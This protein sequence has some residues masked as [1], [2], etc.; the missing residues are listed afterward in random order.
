[1]NHLQATFGVEIECYLP[2]G[3]SAALAATAV[4]NRLQANGI[5]RDCK[6]ETLNK[7]VVDHWKIVPDGSLYDVERGVEFV[8]PKLL[9]E[10]GLREVEIVANALTDFGCSVSRNCGLHV[11]VGT[12]IVDVKFFKNLVK[13]YSSFEPVIDTLVPPS[14]RASSSQWCR[15][16]TSARPSAVD[17]ARDYNELC[18]VATPSG[19]YTKLN[20]LPYVRQKTVE[21]RQHSGSLDGA[22]INNWIIFCLR[23]VATA[24]RDNLNLGS[25][26]PSVN[27]ARRGTKAFRIG[28]MFLRPE[29]VTGQEVCREM[30]WPSVSMPVQARAAGIEF[31]TQRVGRQVR[32]F[33][34]S[35]QETQVSVP[36]TL[37]GLCQ[38][39]ES[40]DAEKDYLH[41]RARDLSGGVA[42]AA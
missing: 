12:G 20:L 38:T 5:N 10:A 7:R 32:Y 21:F 16:L 8:A 18:R 2:V 14:R 4:R 24:K 36:L 1:M 25:S 39:I 28:E 19:K 9:G 35:A 31:T 15:S 27:R 17:A 42:W 26:G 33:A 11:H 41:R 13:L 30:G 34:R 6:V 40:S 3:S 37:D 22:K 23:M 29:G